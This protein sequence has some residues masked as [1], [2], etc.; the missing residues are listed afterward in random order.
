M[1]IRR[2]LTSLAFTL[3]I[4]LT[5]GCNDD[6][7][8]PV[9]ATP[10]SAPRSTPA[11]D[12]RL[13]VAHLS[14]DAPAVDVLV[15]GTDNLETISSN[16]VARLSFTPAGASAPVVID[17]TL[18]LTTGNVYTVA[19]TGLLSQNDLQPL[20]LL[21]D[22]ST[23]SGATV[24]FVHTGPDAPGV[25]LAVT[26]GPILFSDITFRESSAYASVDAGTYDLEVR[27][28]GTNT[29]ALSVPGLNLSGGTT[30]TV[31]AIGLLSDGSLAALPIVDAM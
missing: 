29:V 6:D 2:A 25:D 12:V 22:L 27:V 19:A 17:A 3:P 7:P 30:Y 18:T 1:N 13:R 14:P 28:A 9:S 11:P 5:F 8:S 20:V 15:D 21:D 16:G 10:V 31:F 26:G 4:A 24:R 23:T